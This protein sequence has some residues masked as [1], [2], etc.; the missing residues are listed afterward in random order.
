MK[1]FDENDQNREKALTDQTSVS[2]ISETIEADKNYF[3]EFANLVSQRAHGM[4][5]N[6]FREAKANE[7]L[8]ALRRGIVSTGAVYHEKDRK[9]LEDRFALYDPDDFLR[10]IVSADIFRRQYPKHDGRTDVVAYQLNPE[11]YGLPPPM[12]E[13]VPQDLFS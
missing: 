4:N 13:T 5:F 9:K 7:L 8:D 3:L 6:E 12:G 11:K 1:P 10:V 2:T